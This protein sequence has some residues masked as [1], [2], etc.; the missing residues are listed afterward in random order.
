MIKRYFLPGYL[1]FLLIFTACSV[2][3]SASNFPSANQNQEPTTPRTLTICL[4]EEPESLYPYMA[5]SLAARDVLQA[6]YDGPIDNQNGEPIPV[7][8]E[9]IPNLKDGSAYFTPVSVNPGEAVINTASDMVRLQSGVQ[10][11]PSGCTMTSCAITWDGITPIRM[12]YLT[13]IF[14]LKPG[15][16]WSDGQPLQAPDSVYSFNIASDPITPTNKHAIDQ[17]AS[18]TEKDVLTIQWV[19]KPGLVTD[20]F[21]DFFWIPLPEH[22]WGKYNAAE[23]MTADEVNR[24][25]LGWG[26]YQVEEWITGKSIRL[27]KNGHYFRAAEGFPY[28]DTLIFKII[29]SHGDTALSNLKF[30]RTPFQQFN[31]DVGEYDKEI[32]E[33]GCDLTTTTSDMHDQFSVLHILLNYF[34]E[35]AIKV[36]KSADEE[37]DL[38]LF[39]NRENV[40]EYANSL[41]ILDVRKAVNLCLDREKATKD[42]SFGLYNL[43]DA[44]HF[45]KNGIDAQEAAGTLYDPE[46][47]AALLDQAG[48]KD[49]DHQS[50]TPRQSS[51]IPGVLDGKEL[52]FSYLVEDISDNL[53][54]A[55][56]FKASLGECGISINIKSVPTETFWNPSHEDSIFQ[57]HFDLA[58]LTWVT[59][60]TDPCSLFSSQYISSP[61]NHYLET[62][63]SGFKDEEFDLACDLL[64]TTHL[65]NDREMLLNKMETIIQNEL[66]A[67]PLYSYSRLLVAQKDFCPKGLDLIFKNELVGLERFE[68]LS[69]CP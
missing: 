1:A 58:Q 17:T 56:I 51:G 6:I 42:L 26:A 25:P 49:H 32:S 28:F 62:N 10:V 23:L 11:F 64:K 9:K 61:E 65:K 40:G 18:Y 2:P 35:P 43:P 66:P 48:W 52:N 38:L 39:N 69:N 4:G 67:L 44:I 7:I 21:E 46:S 22:A 68:I 41:S 60:V 3:Q 30:D 36:F 33:N 8:L 19:S 15:L 63:F 55:E 14:K 31:Y 54:S 20:A 57:G 24:T 27:I 50:K 34:Q 29:N 45:T 5:E 37:S 16:A 13:S 47:G 53:K 59:P 12:D